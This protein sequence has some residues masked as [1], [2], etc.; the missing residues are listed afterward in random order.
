MDFL[1][2]FFLDKYFL[3]PISEKTFVLEQSLKEINSFA[4]S[5]KPRHVVGPYFDEWIEDNILPN[6]MYIKDKKVFLMTTVRAPL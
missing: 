1:Q 6:L 5:I 2:T 3:S 4:P